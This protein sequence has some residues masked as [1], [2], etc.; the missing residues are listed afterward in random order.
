[1]SLYL[2]RYQAGRPFWQTMQ[3]LLQRS[4]SALIPM[5]TQTKLPGQVLSVGDLFFKAISIMKCSSSFF[6]SLK[7]FKF[8]YSY[9]FCNGNTVILKSNS[10][11]LS[12][13]SLQSQLPEGNGYKA[14]QTSKEANKVYCRY[15][16]IKGTRP[17][18]TFCFTSY[19]MHELRNP[20]RDFYWLGPM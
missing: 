8:V 11:L 13:L 14:R 20:N 6:P 5:F 19:T 12:N 7:A 15:Y 3:Q 4:D 10:E 17:C 18:T 2:E 9:T 16:Y 1:M